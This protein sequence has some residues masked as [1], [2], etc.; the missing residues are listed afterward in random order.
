MTGGDLEGAKLD[1]SLFFP[2][3]IKN[4]LT[5]WLAGFPETSIDG[6]DIQV[7]QGT[8][9]KSVVKLYFDKQSGLLVRQLRYASTAVGLNPT[10]VDYSD[11]RDVSGVKVPFHWTL[12]W[13]DGQ[14]MFD[15][16]SVQPN[17]AIDGEKFAKPHP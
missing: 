12:S 9:G 16:N 15:L 8:I 11:Y 14:S 10:Q 4:S 6:H 7:I 13:T 2:G 17:V 3:Q 1:A 5:K